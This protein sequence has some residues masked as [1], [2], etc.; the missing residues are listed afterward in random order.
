MP[1]KPKSPY[2]I[3]FVCG[4]C[5]HVLHVF[6]SRKGRGLYHITLRRI[7]EI[8]GGVCPRC[9]KRFEKPTR[10]EFKTFK[11]HMVMEASTSTRHLTVRIPTWMYDIIMKFI[12]DGK[13]K[14]KTEFIIKAILKMLEEHGLH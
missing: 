7:Y 6:K 3:L 5:K 12:A 2:K 9:G 4:G 8:Y 11:E 14:S 10:L 1:F 13:F